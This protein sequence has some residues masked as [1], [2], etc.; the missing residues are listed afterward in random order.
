MSIGTWILLLFSILSFI[1]LY[2]WLPDKFDLGKIIP[3]LCERSKRY[4]VVRAIPF[5]FFGQLLRRKHLTENKGMVAGL[6]IILSICVGIYTGILL[7]VVNARPFWNSPILPLV[8]LISALKTGTASISLTGIFL[9]RSRNIN[10]EEI[11]GCSF[12]LQ[13]FDF[14]LMISFLIVI[15]LY[16]FGFYVSSSSYV[17]AIQLIMGGEF[18][19]SF[20]VLV[21]GLGTAFP[22]IFSAYELIPHFNENAKSRNHSPLLV[23][24]VHVSR[25]L[26]RICFAVCGGLCRADRQGD[27]SLR[28]YPLISF[29]H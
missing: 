12:F 23:G 26:R 2:I 14:A 13:A 10:R 5:E 6:G 17:K 29:R 21:I 25:P 20:W 8:F 9:K 11:K 7:G 16:I 22:L 1:H 24:I 3:E 28:T 27:F 19:F 18:T 15:S 4:P